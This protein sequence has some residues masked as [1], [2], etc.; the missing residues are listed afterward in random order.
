MKKFFTLIAVAMMA[1]GG[2]MAQTQTVVLSHPTKD[3]ANVLEGAEQLG[4]GADGWKVLCMNEAKT[5]DQA[6]FSFTINGGTYRSMKLSNGAQTKICLPEGKVATKLTIYSTGNKELTKDNYW[7]EVN[8]ETFESTK[9]P[10]TSGADGENPSV[11]TFTINRTNTITCTQKGDQQ[12]V[13]FVVE[14]ESGTGIANINADS[15]DANAP[16]YNLAGQRVNANAKGLVIKNGKKYV[17][18]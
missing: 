12:C 14:Y 6:S 13:V 7:L 15:D 10:M 2:A 17:N 9:Y 16:A 1:V 18:K 4:E 3:K 11:N 8:D 5:L